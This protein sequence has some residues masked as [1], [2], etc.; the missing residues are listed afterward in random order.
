M[1]TVGLLLVGWRRGEI[2]GRACVIY[3]QPHLRS[4]EKGDSPGN[5]HE[6]QALNTS[7]SKALPPYRE[8]RLHGSS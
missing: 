4:W 2:C 7:L 8:G 3:V 6:A 5:Q 1:E